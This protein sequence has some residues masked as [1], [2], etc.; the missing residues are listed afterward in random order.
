MA[1][2]SLTEISIN[3]SYDIVIIG[4]G[5]A[6]SSAARAATQ[7]GVKVLLI[8]RKQRIGLPVQCAELVSQWISHHTCFPSTCILQLIETMVIHLPDRTSHVMR[9][10][11][12]MLDRSLFDKELV[13]S[14]VLSGTK[15][16]TET[17]A[18]GI[19]SDGVLVER[20]QKQEIIK[21]KVIIGADGVHSSVARWLGLPPVKT[22][23]ALQYEVV[24]PYS[25]SHADIFFHPDY[26][27]GY[28]WFFPKGRTA[29]VGLGVISHK[30]SL[31]PDLMN[32]FLKNLLGSDRL[33]DIHIVGKTG[34]SLPCEKPRQTVFGNIL[35][36]G[37]AAGHTHPITG[38][39]ILHAVI[40]GE[41][42]GR[43]AAEAVQ[44]G[45][46]RYLEN[47][48]IEW[49]GTFGQSLSY[50]ASKR[51]FLEEHWNEPGVEFE[52]L[53]QK[54]WVGF[55]KYHEDRKRS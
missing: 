40:G 1:E 30:I 17:K 28:A 2:S 25:Q 37:D 23:V 55:K 12:F 7:K 51:K 41:I 33:T 20:G 29:N 10:P 42:A 6:G 4:A 54:T 48:E 31:L 27:G 19:S 21:A 26:E 24:N 35:L 47:Y 36:I 46:L 9:G 53:V 3:E 45:D 18:T 11:G 43:I 50:G 8:D 16:L 49:R 5:P 13:V 38:A 14:A 44:K 15:I 32:H 39:G 22:I 52:D 34:G